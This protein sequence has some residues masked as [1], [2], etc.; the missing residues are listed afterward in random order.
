MCLGIPAQITTVNAESQTATVDVAGIK[1]DVNI[2][3]VMDDNQNPLNLLGAW[4][5]VHVG[6]AMSVIDE[7]EAKRT[8]EL[9][10]QLGEMEDEIQ[11]MQGQDSEVY[12]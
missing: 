7:D 4:V 3:C 12:P 10:D 8:L 1:R 11:A 2:A 6:F 5:L 9:L